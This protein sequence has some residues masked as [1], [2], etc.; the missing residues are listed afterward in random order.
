M[1]RRGCFH[2]GAKISLH[3][4]IP[5]TIVHF[6]QECHVVLVVNGKMKAMKSFPESKELD[7]EVWTKVTDLLDTFKN[8]PAVEL[9][10]RKLRNNSCMHKESAHKALIYGHLWVNS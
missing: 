8:N 1:A 10:L 9:P 6:V 3:D 7:Q 5:I 2:S 4:H